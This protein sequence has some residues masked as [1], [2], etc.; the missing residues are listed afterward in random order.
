MCE[1][2]GCGCGCGCGGEKKEY[3]CSKCGCTSS[4][5]CKCCGEDMQETDK[6]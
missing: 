4:H 3:K 2:C 1:E 6:K 5:Q